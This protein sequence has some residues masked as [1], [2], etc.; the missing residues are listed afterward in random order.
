MPFGVSMMALQ[1]WILPSPW[2]VLILFA[3]IAGYM[4][5]CLWV[6]RLPCPRCHRA[7]APLFTGKRRALWNWRCDSCGCEIGDPI[8]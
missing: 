1:D 3:Y 7:F 8:A 2:P 5:V 6:G 4:A